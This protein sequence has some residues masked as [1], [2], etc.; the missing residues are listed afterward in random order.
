MSPNQSGELNISPLLE[1]F[2]FHFGYATPFQKWK[3]KFPKKDMLTAETP[4]ID[5]LLA[6]A[7]TDCGH[8]EILCPPLQKVRPSQPASSAGHAEGRLPGRQGWG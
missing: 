1:Y 8:H 2:R 3:E 4:R 6:L 5:A 7:P